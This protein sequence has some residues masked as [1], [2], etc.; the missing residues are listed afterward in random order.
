MRSSLIDTMR[1]D[2]LVLVGGSV[3]S[4]AVLS[5]FIEQIRT[6]HGEPR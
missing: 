1:E 3:S 6:A 4:P 5:P 2:F